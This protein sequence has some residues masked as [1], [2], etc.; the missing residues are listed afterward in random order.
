M[1][2]PMRK[3]RMPRPQTFR[4]GTVP[5]P[6]EG[7]DTISSLTEM[8]KLRAVSLINMIR[9]EGGLRSRTG[10]AAWVDNI[11]AGAEV[12]SILPYLG[13]AAGGA[14]NKLF[15]CT[16]A[17]IY[18][19]TATGTAPAQSIAF[20]TSDANSGYGESQIFVTAA[21]RFLLY[22]DE[23]N[24]Y[25]VWPEGGPWAAVTQG[26]GAT[27]VN[28]V[29]PN[30]FVWCLSFKNRMWFVERGSTRAW[31]LP[32]NSIYGAAASFD[33][34]QQFQNGG[35][36]VGLYSF[37]LD[38]GSGMDDLL[39]AVS[40]AGDVVIYGGTDPSSAVTF[41]VVGRWNVGGVPAGRRLAS[42]NTGGELFLLSHFGLIPCSKL[43][44]GRDVLAVDVAA[45][46]NIRSLFNA[47]MNDRANLTGWSVVA[48][49]QDAS[50]L[51]TYPAL[52]GEQR[53][54][55][56]M[57]QAGQGW[58][59]YVAKPILTGKI[60]NRVMYFGT[61]DGRV[62]K[63]T[64]YI[65]NV[66]RDG[67]T[68]LAKAISWSGQTAFSD[69]D[70]AELKQLQFLIARFVTQGAN[71]SIIM[72][73][74]YDFDQTPIT[75]SPPT[76]DLPANAWDAAVWDSGVFAGSTAIYKTIQGAYGLGTHVSIAWIGSSVQRMSLIA[77]NAA[78][79]KGGSL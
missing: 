37:T 12:R 57:A 62:M 51:I 76:P 61:T 69:L 11:N 59:Q 15:A 40:S 24:G 50:I 20:A 27:Q 65:D 53:Q 33:F 5:V 2:M 68:A 17:G 77:F 49:P 38:G 10:Y 18:D 39:V 22:T 34:G 73:P 8:G 75:L 31:Y 30:T 67:S 9:A 72:Q 1:P 54:Q 3:R 60:F 4:T 48:D 79:T 14:Q 56:A 21:G 71:P 13:S 45:T 64:G 19:V 46:D 28:N 23:S 29:N 16:T 66:A 55:F 52:V 78:V 32:L 42:K 43:V 41:G 35:Y 44:K 25:Y 36:L 70:A 6:V 58:S 47:T 63:S 7:I 74:R 26:V